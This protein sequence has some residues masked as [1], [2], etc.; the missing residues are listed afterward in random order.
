[1]LQF[2]VDGWIYLQQKT[3][4]RQLAAVSDIGKYLFMK[5][6]GQWTAMGLW[7]GLECSQFPN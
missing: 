7:R 6:A 3:A 2:S 4:V 1:M 5:R